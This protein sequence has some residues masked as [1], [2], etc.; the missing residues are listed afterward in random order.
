MTG[1]ENGG[2]LDR[3][4]T[5]ARRT[6][7]NRAF[8]SCDRV[9]VPFDVSLDAS[10]RQIADP[11][12]Q[13]LADGRVF[14]EEPEADALDAS[15]DQKMSGHEHAPRL[16]RT[17]ADRPRAGPTESA[18][19][20][21][22]GQRVDR[23]PAALHSNADDPCRLTVCCTGSWPTAP[24][25]PLHGTAVAQ[26]SSEGTGPQRCPRPIAFLSRRFVWSRAGRDRFH[27]RHRRW[28]ARSAGTRSSALIRIGDS[29]AGWRRLSVPAAEASTST[30]TL[31]ARWFGGPSPPRGARQ[32]AD[33]RQQ[34]D[35]RR[36]SPPGRRDACSQPAVYRLL[37]SLLAGTPG[38]PPAVSALQISEVHID[39]LE[40]R[41]QPD[42]I[43]QSAMRQSAITR[44]PAGTPTPR[45]A[46]RTQRSRSQMSGSHSSLAY[47]TG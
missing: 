13:S 40:T 7:S 42:P 21:T 31:G 11:P 41:W 4:H 33:G 26:R 28:P 32:G 23:R 6:A 1:W 9:G 12:V 14:G 29:E 46:P 17:P 27:G 19:F 39:E 38:T 36:W 16:Y 47:G 43:L 2:H 25:D 5:R 30:R 8:E 20:L 44:F 10:V 37:L 35:G 45:A 18:K 34:A 3:I 22:A 15:T 24:P